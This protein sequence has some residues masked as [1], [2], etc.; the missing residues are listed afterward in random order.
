MFKKK[1]MMEYVLNIVLNA[2]KKAN[3]KSALVNIIF[4][5]E[6]KKVMMNQ[7]FAQI[8]HQNMDIIINLNMEKI[9]I[10]DV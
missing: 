10:I 9:I 1:E 7:L 4:I 2:Q 8:E 5:L 3:A 6:I